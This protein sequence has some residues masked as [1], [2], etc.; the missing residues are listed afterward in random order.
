MLPKMSNIPKTLNSEPR[1]LDFHADTGR[2][3]TQIETLKEKSLTKVVLVP[4]TN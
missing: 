1:G 3:A 2:N 4:E